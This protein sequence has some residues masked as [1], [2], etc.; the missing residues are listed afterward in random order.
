MKNQSNAIRKQILPLITLGL[1]IVNG[2]LIYQNFS[3]KSQLNGKKP[4]EIKEAD[5]LGEFEAE[6]LDGG[7]ERITYN[8]TGAK[9]VLLY[10]H[11]K[12][13]WCKKQMPYWKELVSNADSQRFEITA[14][15]NDSNVDELKG[16]INDYSINP[17][18]VLIISE[19]DVE[20]AHLNGT[21]ITVV[22]DKHGKVEKVW[23]GMW[24]KNDL[25]EIGNYFDI[26]FTP[27]ENV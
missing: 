24:R 19:A 15:T 10:F 1:L 18:K 22:L 6:N 7:I 23:I 4:I 20:K 21:P 3:L 25:D 27:Q 8:Q 26:R 9:R 5:V 11:P 13:G 17:W 16:F 2:L 14:I 12:C